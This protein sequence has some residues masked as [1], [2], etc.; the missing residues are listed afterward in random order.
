[1]SSIFPLSYDIPQ[2]SST[3]GET[4]SLFSTEK[5]ICPDT[6]ISRLALPQGQPSRSSKA[7]KKK[8]NIYLSCNMTTWGSSAIEI[9]FLMRYPLTAFRF[10]HYSTKI[11]QVGKSKADTSLQKCFVISF[12]VQS[13]LG[14]NAMFFF[15][16]GILNKVRIPDKVNC[17]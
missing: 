3:R 1:M 2:L 17:T 7:V 10:S 15:I 13:S 6:R 16:P 5:T 8:F 12:N 9:S 14:L 11:A 4:D